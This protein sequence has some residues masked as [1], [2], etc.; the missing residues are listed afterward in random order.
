MDLKDRVVL[1]AGGSGL[2][3]TAIARA[4]ASALFLPRL[5][6]R[7]LARSHRLLGICDACIAFI[8]LRH[9]TDLIRGGSR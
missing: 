1:V 5:V 3:G 8:H 2:L 6:E 4:L 9:W 7:A